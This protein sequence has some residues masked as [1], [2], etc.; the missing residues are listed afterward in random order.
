[1]TSRRRELAFFSLYA[2]TGGLIYAA[3][4]PFWFYG[5]GFI[6]AKWGYS[7]NV[8][9]LLM[10]LT[11]GGMVVLSPP[12]GIL[13]DAHLKDLRRRL[14]ALALC[15]MAIP[16]A[17]VLLAFVPAAVMPP[18]ISMLLLSLGYHHLFG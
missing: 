6:R 7:L 18:L 2:T 15:S 10:L 17:F 1:M 16:T 13:V 5:G 12:L 3:I 8:A 11:E 9:D 4:V 14:M